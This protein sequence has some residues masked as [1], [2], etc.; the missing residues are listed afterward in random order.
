[1]A[2][3]QHCLLLKPEDV[4]VHWDLG[5]YFRNQGFY[6][7]A[8]EHCDK[9]LKLQDES[10]DPRVFGDKGRKEK[11][12][13]ELRTQ[14]E[15]L[16]RFF[17]LKTGNYSDLDKVR[18]IAMKEPFDFELPGGGKGREQGGYGL[19][20]KAWELAHDILKNQLPTYSPAE[21][22]R[23]RIYYIR[24]ALEIGILSVAD[25]MIRDMKPE[26]K[27]AG[28]LE[29]SYRYQHY[30]IL[31]NAAEG[32]FAQAD[33]AVAAIE[34]LTKGQDQ[35][36]MLTS[37]G[38]VAA[39][40]FMYPPELSLGV[41]QTFPALLDMT[42]QFTLIQ[43]EKNDRLVLRGLFALES[44]DYQYEGTASFSRPWPTRGFSIRIVGSPMPLFTVDAALFRREMN[45]V[46][47]SSVQ[48]TEA[49]ESSFP[50]KASFVFCLVSQC[51]DSGLGRRPYSPESLDNC[52]LKSAP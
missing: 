43:I 25:R 4:K 21:Q 3:L 47:S 16:S 39:A 31:L 44:G 36:K 52:L 18:V 46:I 41:M 23:F 35:A 10:P 20:L 12:V 38:H 45:D 34:E 27:E 42:T 13:G 5:L 40:N 51:R 30:M 1:M 15:G 48:F 32:D 19:W 22:E 8:L 2:A 14:V 37:I 11:F 17:D 50:D 49:A 28:Y 9:S 26:P 29:R 7:L 33:Q 6:D 24:L